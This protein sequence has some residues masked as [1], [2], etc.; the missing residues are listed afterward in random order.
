MTRSWRRSC[1][2]EPAIKV[3]EVAERVGYPDSRYF[4][5]LFKKWTDLTPTE[6]RSY[7]MQEA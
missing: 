2:T 6:F 1:Y 3:Y 5:T 7:Y 4:S